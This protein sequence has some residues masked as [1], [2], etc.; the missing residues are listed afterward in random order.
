MK[1]K[2]ILIDE[3]TAF[4]SILQTLQVWQWCKQKS[5]NA[6]LFLDLLKKYEEDREAYEI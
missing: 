6:E 5:N 2:Y 4:L 3:I 1:W